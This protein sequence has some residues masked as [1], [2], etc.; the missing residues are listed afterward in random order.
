[1]KTKIEDIKKKSVPILKENDV[2]FAAVFGSFARGGE[3]TKSDI[4]ILIRFG[5]P[6]KSLLDL[7][8]LENDLSEVLHRK[9]DLVT[10]NGL[11]PY[12]RNNVLGDLKVIYGK[13]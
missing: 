7:V 13:R 2:A 1:M 8:S 4:D 6:K 10:E 3:H 12:I 11:H 9:V 5:K